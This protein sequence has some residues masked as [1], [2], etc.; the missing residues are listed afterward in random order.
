MSLFLCTSNGQRQWQ[1]QW[2]HLDAAFST[3]TLTIGT[4]FKS[5]QCCCCWKER[6]DA[7]YVQ[8]SP[9]PPDTP[10][11]YAALIW[12]NRHTISANSQPQQQSS[13][14]LISF[15]G[16]MSQDSLHQWLSSSPKGGSSSKEEL[17]DAEDREVAGTWLC[18]GIIFILAPQPLPIMLHLCT[19]DLPF[20]VGLRVMCLN[21]PLTRECK[22]HHIT[23][24]QL[25]SAPVLVT[26]EA[27]SRRS[28][29]LASQGVAL[30]LACVI[31]ADSVRKHSHRQGSYLR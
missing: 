23:K 9:R 4:E 26:G 28:S 18:G 5:F 19:S 10:V 15:Q 16:E 27:A 2:P 22:C 12:I 8:T 31:S 14:L 24:P 20:C 7:V 29:R 13:S 17:S 6:C 21:K 11:E 25:P 1:Q 30:H 3:V